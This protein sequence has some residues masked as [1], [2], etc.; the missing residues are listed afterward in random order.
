MGH[1]CLS[2]LPSR[3]RVSDAPG[4]TTPAAL[5]KR[6]R[7]LGPRPEILISFFGFYFSFWSLVFYFNYFLSL[8]LA[9]HRVVMVIISIRMAHQAC[10]PLQINSASSLFDLAIYFSS[11]FPLPFSSSSSSSLGLVEEA[12]S[13]LTFVFFIASLVSLPA[14]SSSSPLPSTLPLRRSIR[15]NCGHR[16]GFLFGRFSFI[17]WQIVDLTVLIPV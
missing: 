13:S 4:K 5:S 14:Q 6:Q 16:Y 2:T 9:S 1:Q 3:S 8:F 11:L 17:V 10:A 12:V 15:A 7:P